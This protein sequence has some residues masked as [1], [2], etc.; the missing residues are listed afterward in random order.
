MYK[1]VV[2]GK[3]VA[4][5]RPRLVG[6]RVYT[7][8]ETHDY[9]ALVRTAARRAGV[10][11]IVGSVSLSVSFYMPTKHHVDVDNLLKSVMDGLN[12]VAYE[13]DT[14]VV[15]VQAWKSYDKDQPRCSIFIQATSDPSES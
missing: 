4:K 1:V 13:D 3:P 10:K 11:A 6:T 2:K 7:P 9:E 8:K 15:H 14:Q 5:Q 12:G